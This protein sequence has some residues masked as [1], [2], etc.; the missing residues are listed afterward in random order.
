[1]LV[2]TSLISNTCSFPIS[3][4][5]RTSSYPTLDTSSVSVAL[6]VDKVK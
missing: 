4:G 5:N 3:I 1:M 2:G 6:G